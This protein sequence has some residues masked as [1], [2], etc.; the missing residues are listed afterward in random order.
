VRRSA[1][2]LS[3]ALVWG[4][5]PVQQLLPPTTSPPNIVVILTDDQRLDQLAEMPTVQ[6][7][8]VAKGMTFQQFFVNNPLCCPSRATI[9]TGTLNHTNGVYAVD[10]EKPNGG[11][12]AFVPNESR[13]IAVALDNAGYQTGLVGKY[14]NEYDRA[15]H[16]PPGWDFWAANV[17]SDRYR[18]QPFSVNGLYTPL[19]G[20]ATDV[21]RNYATAFIASVP[22]GVPLFLYF[23]PHAPHGP[24]TPANRHA[25]EFDTFDPLLPPSFRE[26]DVSD[27]PAYVRNRPPISSTKRRA[28]I[29]LWRQQLESLLAVDEAIAAI[30]RE[31][32]VT[33]RLDDTII[34]FTSDNGLMLGEHRLD[35]VKNVPYEEA[36]HQPLIVRWDRH[37][38]T[39][40]T[41]DHLVG[42]VDLAPTWAEAGGTSLAGAEGMSFLP[43]LLGAEPSWRQYLLIEHSFSNAP[44][45]CQVHGVGHSYISYTTG[46]EELYDLTSDPYQLVNVAANPSYTAIRAELRRQ[47]DVLCVP[48]PP[49]YRL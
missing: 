38:Q 11:W 43:I 12:D 29:S 16:V 21:M 1:A 35:R 39:G 47:R 24:A 17:N 5:A 3:A 27:K 4:L 33:G 15:L 9:L 30:L 44:P 40:S 25:T 2:L 32:A 31:L 49:G 20:Y 28:I 48:R 26:A 10:N 18:N 23:A 37:V 14:M 46:E 13:T 45:F 7:E 34:V 36:V 8:L 6:R 19:P 42:A 22:P 41:D